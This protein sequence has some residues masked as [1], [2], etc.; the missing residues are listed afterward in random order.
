[1]HKN[2]KG[3]L[4]VHNFIRNFSFMVSDAVFQYFQVGKKIFHAVNKTA[5]LT[6]EKIY[7]TI[8]ALGKDKQFFFS[9]FPPWINLNITW[10]QSISQ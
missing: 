6:F 3:N 8:Y 5:K 10:P 2:V 4:L 7:Q 9:T 1:M